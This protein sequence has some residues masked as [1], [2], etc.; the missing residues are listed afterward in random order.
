MIR[1]RWAIATL[2]AG[3]LLA[4]CS[5]DDPE[6]KIDAEPTPSETSPSATSSSASVNTSPTVTPTPPVD[7]R[8][9]VDAWLQA[10]TLA[11]TSGITDE[12]FGLSA[13]T[14]VSC[15]RLID[16]VADLYA[17]GGRLETEGWRASK[18]SE[19]PD[20]VVATPSYVMQV[21]EA[22]QILYDENNNVADNTPASTVPM[23]MTFELRDQKWVLGKLEILK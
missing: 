17:K 13:E 14:C 18:V 15:Q 22:R 6:P 4:G 12:V 16:Q 20:S 3:C 1:T 11:M 8:A 5:E 19:A 9:A 7:P 23:R 10:W 2:L 21:V